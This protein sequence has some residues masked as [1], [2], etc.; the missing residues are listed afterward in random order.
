MA[1][2]GV[3]IALV[4][5]HRGGVEARSFQQVFGIV[6]FGDWH[7]AVEV[8]SDV[9]G[10]GWWGAVGVGADVAVEIVG[11]QFVEGD[12]LGEAVDIGEVSVG[13]GDL[14]LVARAYVVL[15]ATFAIVAV[16]VDEQHLALPLW[17]FGSFGSQDQDGG[18]DAGAVEQVRT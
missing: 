6:D 10:F 9:V 11:G 2:V 13:G 16:G 15:G 12:D 14:L 3:A 4:D 7:A 18:G 5:E 17:G 8:C 1:P